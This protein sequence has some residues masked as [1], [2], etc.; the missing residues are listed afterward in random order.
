MQT[1]VLTRAPEGGH[2]SHCLLFGFLGQKGLRREFLNAQDSGLP[3]WPVPI[4]LCDHHITLCSLGASAE[5]QMRWSRQSAKFSPAP[6]SLSGLG[7]G[8]GQAMP[9]RVLRRAD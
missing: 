7:Q 3:S 5:E 9:G 1:R 6:N 4:V 2:A 8:Q